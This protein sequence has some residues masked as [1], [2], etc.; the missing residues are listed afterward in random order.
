MLKRRLMCIVCVCVFC[1]LSTQSKHVHL[2]LRISWIDCFR[3]YKC[4]YVWIFVCFAKTIP[5]CV[6]SL[7]FYENVLYQCRMFTR[8]FLATHNPPTRFTLLGFFP[9]F[10]F[11][12][13][14]LLFTCMCVVC[15]YT[16]T[17]IHIFIHNTRTHK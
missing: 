2:S 13:L 14:A 17:H 10:I 1:R 5:V 16:H 7:E 6:C 12:L 15:A 4:V 9:Y 11:A 8:D 3:W